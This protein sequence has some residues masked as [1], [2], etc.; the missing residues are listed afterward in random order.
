MR[1]LDNYLDNTASSHKTMDCLPDE[2]V[3]SVL[4]F[5]RFK[6]AYSTGR[7][8]KRF[9]SLLS[10]AASELADGWQNVP[11]LLPAESPLKQLAFLYARRGYQKSSYA[12]ASVILK[13]Q[14]FPQPPYAAVQASVSEPD[15][16]YLLDSFGYALVLDRIGRVWSMGDNDYGG[17]GRAGEKRLEYVPGLPSPVASVTACCQSSVAVL[18][19]GELWAWGRNLQFKLGM[20]DMPIVPFPKRLTVPEPVAQVAIGAA[21]MLLTTRTG[22]AYGAGSNASSQLGLNDAGPYR[23]FTLLI[24]WRNERVLKVA[25]GGLYSM[26]LLSTGQVLGCGHTFSGELGCPDQQINTVWNSFTPV[27]GRLGSIMDIEARHMS[28]ALITRLGQLYVCGYNR[29]GWK[30]V[31]APTLVN[32][33]EPVASCT[34]TNTLGVVFTTVS[35][36]TLRYCGGI[37]K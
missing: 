26:L 3:L 10:R 24:P 35:G 36:R 34:L 23:G 17:L 32:E 14:H 7:T 29:V 27:F 5:L 16:D 30:H 8:C 1:L 19:N 2:L 25:A 15:A 31:Y 33:Q 22:R 37:K 21:H 9:Y 6:C 20:E 11:P 12:E 4:G 18:N 13:L 28:T